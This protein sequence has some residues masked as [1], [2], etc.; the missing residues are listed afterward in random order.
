MVRLQ[1]AKKTFDRGYTPNWTEELFKVNNINQDYVPT[2]YSVEDDEGEEIEG[3]FYEAEMQKVEPI[4]RIE[5]II[6]S[7]MIKGRKHLLV[8]WM[9]DRFP[10]PEWIPQ[11]DLI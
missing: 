6:K 11:S 9:G 3:R 10:Q 4:Y 5:R 8:K 7:K 1:K 2:T